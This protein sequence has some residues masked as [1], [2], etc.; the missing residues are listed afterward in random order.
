[1]S[2]K[3][4]VLLARH[5]ALACF[6]LI[7]YASL[8][9]FTGWYISGISPFVFLEGAWPRYWTFFDLAVNA[10]GYLP[11]GFLLALALARIP[12][13]FSAVL[14]ATLIASATSFTLESLQVFLPSRVPSNLDFACNSMGGLIG[15]ILAYW[16]GPRFFYRLMIWQRRLIAPQPH[17]ELGLTL[18]AL[19]LLIPISPEILLFGAGDV[20]SIFDLAGAVPFS[21]YSSQPMETAVI[22]CNTITI[23]LL[24]RQLTNSSRL[25]F[26]CIPAFILLGLLVRSLAAAILV[27][28]EQ[29]FSWWTLAAQ[30]GLF[31]G[32]L[33][34]LPAIFLST[35][36]RL[37]LAALALMCGA[38]LVNITPH[39]PYSI[40]ALA[41]WRQGHFFN[42]NGLTRLVSIFW[43]FLALLFLMFSSRRANP[44]TPTLS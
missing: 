24:V 28:P 23:G 44:E 34:L 2:T 12:G 13:R 18:L 4:P 10:V 21:P 9:P 37:I 3:G 17:P 38:V 35:S 15:A 42:F 20:R 5:L 27:G 6:A 25:A 40:A 7:V 41:S 11:Y 31:V 29:A 22:A 1:M 43:P 26:A 30:N 14:I 19:W 39:N 8:H 32:C 16:A 36:P 33:I